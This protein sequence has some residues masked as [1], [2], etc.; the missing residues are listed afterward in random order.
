M[1]IK[2][3]IICLTFVNCYNL[4]SQNIPGIDISPIEI[5]ENKIIKTEKY[6]FNNQGEIISERIY[7][8][9]FENDVLIQ[10]TYIL[11]DFIQTIEYFYNNDLLEKSIDYSN[12]QDKKT[13]ITTEYYFDLKNNISSIIVISFIEALAGLNTVIGEVYYDYEDDKVSN[14]LINDYDKIFYCSYD[15][16]YNQDDSINHINYKLRSKN[17]K[18]FYQYNDD[19]VLVKVLVANDKD[20]I[21]QTYEYS[22]YIDGRVAIITNYK[23][24]KIVETVIYQYLGDYDDTIIQYDNDN[25]NTYL[26]LI[27]II[28]IV[29]SLISII[30][31]LIKLFRKRNAI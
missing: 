27:I 18:L 25:P 28:I 9:F 23:K 15:I 13:N 11:G 26:I 5:I 19:K 17:Q 7:K 21:I 4:I 16:N 30:I 3:L 31:F 2:Y 10:T 6:K 14:I 29:F 12:P 22:Y 20:K 8:H 1:K 24:N